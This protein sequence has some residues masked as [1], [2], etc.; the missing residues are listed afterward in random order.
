RAVRRTLGRCRPRVDRVARGEGA[1]LAGGGVVSGAVPAGGRLP[2]GRRAARTPAA[3]GGRV[4]V[5]HPA[6]LRPLPHATRRAGPV[7]GGC[8]GPA[9]DV[10]T[11]SRGRWRVGG[12]DDREPR[13]VDRTGR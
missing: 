7:E 5:R 4:L 11:G 6:A 12:G 10:L 2:L 9:T 13:P 1:E 8:P 3:G